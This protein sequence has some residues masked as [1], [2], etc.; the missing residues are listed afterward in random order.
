MKGFARG[1]RTAFI[2]V[3]AAMAATPA[4]AQVT[5]KTSLTLDGA[6]RVDRGGGTAKRAAS[7]R[8]AP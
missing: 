4:A 8:P 5:E 2:A 6:R 7:R 1:F 3:L